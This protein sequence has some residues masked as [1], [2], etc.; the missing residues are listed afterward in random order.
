MNEAVQSMTG[1]HRR[2][3]HDKVRWISLIVPLCC[4]I[5]TYTATESD[6]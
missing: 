5:W 3:S 1:R 2:L 4:R 6:L